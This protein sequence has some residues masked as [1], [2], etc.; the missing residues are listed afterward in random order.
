MAP[1]IDYYFAPQSPWTYLG[2]AQFARLA[3]AAGAAVRVKPIDLDPDG[4]EFALQ[5]GDVAPMGGGAPAVQQ[6]GRGK[7]ECSGAHARH[8][9]CVCGDAAHQIMVQIVAADERPPALDESLRLQSRK[10]SN[11]FQF[12]RRHSSGKSVG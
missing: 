7:E 12:V 5:L 6:A 10:S 1:V 9:A 3:Q 4:G 2:H 11:D 8:A